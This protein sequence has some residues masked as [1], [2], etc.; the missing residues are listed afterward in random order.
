MTADEVMLKRKEDKQNPLYPDANGTDKPHPLSEVK[1]LDRLR[2]KSGVKP[3][4][5]FDD[6]NNGPDT[7]YDNKPKSAVVVGI[8]FDF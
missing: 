4:V 2:K 7:G 3:F 6:L 1:P 5:K 8:K